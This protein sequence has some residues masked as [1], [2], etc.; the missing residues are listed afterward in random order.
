MAGWQSSGRL[1]TGF[2]AVVGALAVSLVA[3]AAPA[4]AA[5]VNNNS[6]RSSP[7]DTAN[8]RDDVQARQKTTAGP[9]N[10]NPQQSSSANSQSSAGASSSGPSAAGPAHAP[11]PAQ[12]KD[13]PPDRDPH[14]FSPNRTSQSSQTGNS[15]SGRSAGTSP[16]TTFG[17]DRPDD[18]GPNKVSPQERTPTTQD[19]DRDRDRRAAPIMGPSVPQAVPGRNAASGT[20]T[21]QLQ[22]WVPQKRKPKAQGGTHDLAYRYDIRNG[23]RVDPTASQYDWELDDLIGDVGEQLGKYGQARVEQWVDAAG[24]LVDLGKLRVELG[25]ERFLL[26]RAG[27][28]GSMSEMVTAVQK[29]WTTKIEQIRKVAEDPEAATR[30]FVANEWRRFQEDPAT[31]LG[32]LHGQADVVAAEAA[33]AA[34]TR[35]A[36]IPGSLGRRALS[37]TLDTVNDNRSNPD[38]NAPQGG[39]TNADPSPQPPAQPGPSGAP[40]ARPNQPGQD[41]NADAPSAN[42]PQRP[43]N[44]PDRDN[45]RDSATAVPATPG[46]PGSRRDNDRNDDDRPAAIGAPDRSPS[47]PNANRPQSPGAGSNGPGAGPNRGGNSASPGDNKGNK[48]TDAGKGGP[49]GRGGAGPVKKGADGVAQVRRDI[50]A[51]GGRV[52]GSEITV[53]AGGVRTRPDLFARLPGGQLSFVEVK[54]GPGARLTPNQEKAFPI[55]RSQGGVP[56]GANADKTPGLESGVPIGPTPVWVVRLP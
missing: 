6:D 38:P 30:E 40:D 33:I 13:K 28:N 36:S 48:G 47:G 24:D 51:A 26:D 34:A 20:P 17:V 39:N 32:E 4:D 37:E 50:E 9:S 42:S 29:S 49:S 45:D 23:Q 56:R 53:D 5:A 35:G 27:W 41:G 43:G 52:L 14:K 21:G 19:R 3:P 2:A 25:P 55:I 7:N 15:A 11:K 18:R 1:K 12:R 46:A 10:S 8:R 44:P 16:K 31:Y 54:N 22:P